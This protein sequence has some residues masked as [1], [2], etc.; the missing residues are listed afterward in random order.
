[1]ELRQ[2]ADADPARLRYLA[3]QGCD[4]PAAGE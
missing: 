2:V 1:V 4:R 3:E